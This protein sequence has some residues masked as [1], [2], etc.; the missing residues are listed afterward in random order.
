MIPMFQFESQ[1]DTSGTTTSAGGSG[2]GSGIGGF[3]MPSGLH[4]PLGP[5][6]GPGPGPG[7]GF[8]F[9]MG[10][11]VP[12]AGSG[13]GEKRG[14]SRDEVVKVREPRTP[15]ALVLFALFVLFMYSSVL[16]VFWASVVLRLCLS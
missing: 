14:W 12:G 16:F 13:P 11:G 9:G 15:C 2:S 7:A 6:S 8:G 3:G 4:G 5:G 10:V 1:S